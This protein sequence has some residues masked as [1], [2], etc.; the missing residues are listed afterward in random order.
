M[1]TIVIE[2]KCRDIFGQIPEITLNADF[3]SKPYFGWGKLIFY[4]GRKPSSERG[5]CVEN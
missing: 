2:H 1:K 3:S 5:F 4:E